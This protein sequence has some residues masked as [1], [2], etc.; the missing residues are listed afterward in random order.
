[1]P[2]YRGLPPSFIGRQQNSCIRVKKKKKYKQIRIIHYDLD[3]GWGKDIN[4][5][6]IENKLKRIDKAVVERCGYV[7]GGTTCDLINGFP[8]CLDLSKKNHVLIDA[9][10][11][12]EYAYADMDNVGY[13]KYLEKQLDEYN[14]FYFGFKNFFTKWTSKKHL[15]AKVLDVTSGGRF[16]KY[17]SEKMLR[18]PSFK[19]R[20]N[21]N[22][23]YI[24]TTASSYCPDRDGFV[25][26]L[27]NWKKMLRVILE[28]CENNSIK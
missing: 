16:N 14:Y 9:A 20:N 19:K 12:V 11:F 23:L 2:K 5:K 18:V 8:T 22:I 1:M 4:Y 21:G 26:F 10:H 3:D 7:Y 28:I 27:D 25:P 15:K 13:S 17:D 24:Y 6:I